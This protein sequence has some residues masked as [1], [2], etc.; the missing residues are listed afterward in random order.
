MTAA[1]YELDNLVAI[2]DRNEL[3]ITGRTEDVCSLEPLRDKFEAF[4]WHVRTVDGHDVGA[5]TSVLVDTPFKARRPSMIIARTTKGKG[6]SYMEDTA[7]W[8]HGVP[9]DEQFDK[10]MEE[11]E[12]YERLIQSEQP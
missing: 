4:E 6:V 3:Q 7:E 9:D 10:A 12:S 8:H 1:H 2:V 5:L 11:L